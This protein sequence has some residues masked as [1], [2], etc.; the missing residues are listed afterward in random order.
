L[1]SD[2]EFLPKFAI[3]D[4]IHALWHKQILQL[5]AYISE[6]FFLNPVILEELDF[7]EQW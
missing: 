7:F 5:L 2:E 3:A 6:V 1:K 4:D